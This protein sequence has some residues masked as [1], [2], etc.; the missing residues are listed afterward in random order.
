MS[1]ILI[2]LL[3]NERIKRFPD[4][5]FPDI[6]MLFSFTN[7][8]QDLSNYSLLRKYDAI[9]LLNP[10]PI[11]KAQLLFTPLELKTLKRYVRQGGSLLIAVGARGDYG[12]PRP[13]GS[14]RVFY[15]L[16]GITKFQNM[17]LFQ[18]QT[19]LYGVKRTHLRITK[20][21]RHQIFSHFIAGDVLILAKCT[22]FTFYP[23]SHAQVLLKAPEETQALSYTAR[24]QKFNIGSIPLLVINNVHRGRVATI[25]S[26]ELFTANPSCGY[27]AAANLKLLH[28]LFAWL[29]HNSLK[30]T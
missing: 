5:L 2:D 11:S 30:K 27:P 22:G 10:R 14:L 12:I 1:K 13:L 17:L 9:L 21:P 8:L 3:H 24:S 18:T 4:R 15:P 28:G 7:A 19:A 20:F 25:A 16:T 29:L 26:S 6:D 23:E